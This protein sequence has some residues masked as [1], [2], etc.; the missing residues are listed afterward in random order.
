MTLIKLLVL[1]VIVAVFAAR[2]DRP[3]IIVFLSDD[4]GWQQVGY[5]GG[6]DGVPTPN[7]DRLAH[8]GIRLTQFYVQPVCTPTRGALLTGR[9][10]WKTGT[11][12]R[13]TASSRHGMLPD[14]R[15]LAEVL[16]GAGYLTWMV[17]KWH[18]T[19]ITGTTEP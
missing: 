1:S 12:V 11:E 2:A 17:G 15:T 4:M 9:Y 18:L 16:R 6:L 7:I 8:E 19:T 5:N 3:N 10:P 13:P 14:E